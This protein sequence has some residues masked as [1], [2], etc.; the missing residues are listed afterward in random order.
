[1]KW[2]IP[3]EPKDVRHVWTPDATG[4]G[5]LEWFREMNRDRGVEMWQ[6]AGQRSRFDPWFTWGQVLEYGPVTDENPDPQPPSVFWSPGLDALYV[7]E[8][9]KYRLVWFGGE[10]PDRLGAIRAS[11]PSDSR[12]IN[13]QW[14][15]GPRS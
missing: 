4:D 2:E 13:T 10:M 15:P 3:D 7:A 5:H 8:F 1:M 12:P 9:G 11:L 6:L 14:V